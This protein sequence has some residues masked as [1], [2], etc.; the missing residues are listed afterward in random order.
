MFFLLG[1]TLLGTEGWTKKHFFQLIKES[2]AL[3]SFLDDYGARYNRTYAFLTELIASTRWFARAGYSLS[4]LEGRLAS[5]GAERWMEA[6]ELGGALSGLQRGLNIT[7]RSLREL[8]EATFRI[9]SELG[10]ELSREATLEGPFLPVVASRKLPRNVDQAAL[11]DEE[12][13]IA[14]VASKYLQACSMLG[15]VGIRRID[16]SDQLRRAFA[17]HCTEERA[18]V[19]EATV[20]NLQSTYDTHIQNTV[21]EAGD[22]RLSD[23]RGHVSSALHLLEAVTHMAHFIERHEGDIRSEEV[24]QRISTMVDQ[25]EV[26][27]FVWNE[28]LY[29]ANRFLQAGSPLAEDLLPAYTNVGE[30]TFVLADGLNMHARPVSLLV[31]VVQHHGTPVQMELGGQV[32]NAGS[33]LELLVCIGSQADPREFLFRGDERPL[34]DIGLLF[35]HRLGE[36]GLDA[37]PVELAYLRER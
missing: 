13:K 27:D 7:T 37:L 20:H 35:E 25:A 10:L 24:K 5:Y 4:H 14:A 3:E 9:A 8:L 6:A 29:W 2:D 34:R 16:D 26:V 32:C 21:L 36:D 28:L 15:E 12:Q 1:N 31:G 23:L 33:I 11:V 30:A 18:R 17:R 19:Y 22:A